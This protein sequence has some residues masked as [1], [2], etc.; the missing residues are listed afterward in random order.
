MFSRWFPLWSKLKALKTHGRL[1]WHAFRHHDTP[2]W[3]KVF[4]V[5]VVVYLLSPIDLVP[6]FLLWF[7]FTDDLIV[8][9]L[10]MWLLGK[11]IPDAVKLSAP[12]QS[13]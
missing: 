2:L 8:V 5:A 3:I 12:G 6:D 1:M 11:C 9:T 7:G 13:V 4:M 10:A